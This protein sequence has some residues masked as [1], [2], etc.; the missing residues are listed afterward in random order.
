MYSNT[1]LPTPPILGTQQLPQ[2]WVSGIA[3]DGR[4]YYFNSMTNE[5]QWIHPVTGTAHGA[6]PATHRTVSNDPSTE[7]TSGLPKGWE[8]HKTSTGRTYFHNKSAGVTQWS[9]PSEAVAKPAAAGVEKKPAGTV[10]AAK[11]AVSEWKELKVNFTTTM[12]GQVSPNGRTLTLSK[13]RTAVHRRQRQWTVNKRFLTRLNR[14]RVKAS[15]V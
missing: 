6:G 4:V 12:K 13:S 8:E 15:G 3:P 7:S 1:P 5:S 9:N 10:E 11:T 2:G 14:N